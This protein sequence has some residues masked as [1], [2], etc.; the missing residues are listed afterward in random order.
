MNLIKPARTE[1]NGI[2]TIAVTAICLM[3]LLF[4]F[5]NLVTTAFPAGLDQMD[6]QVINSISAVLLLFIFLILASSEKLAERIRIPLGLDSVRT[7]IVI[8][9]TLF[10]LCFLL[11]QY[12]IDQFPFIGLYAEGRIGWALLVILVLLLIAEFFFAWSRFPFLVLMLGL[13]AYGLLVFL[14]IS[15][16][17]WIHSTES[18]YISIIEAIDRFYI[19]LDPYQV[20]DKSTGGPFTQLPG[21]WLLF[22]PAWLKEFDPRWINKITFLLSA[23][24]IY[25]GTVKSQKLFAAHLLSVFMLIPFNVFDN[26]TYLGILTFA[27]ALVYFFFAK[28]YYLLGA[29]AIGWSLTISL[30][31][32][33]IV[34]FALVY[35]FKKQPFFLWLLNIIIT[36]LF[37]SALLVSFWWLYPESFLYCTVEVWGDTVMRNGF[38]IAFLLELLV[39]RYGMIFL[40]VVS[41]LIFFLS[42]LRSQKTLSTFFIYSVFFAYLCVILNHVVNN[43]VFPATCLMIIASIS[44]DRLPIIKEPE[45]E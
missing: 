5:G 3:G 39:G 4:G 23:I 7:P 22:F 20:F 10:T 41:F 29:A 25:F 15:S 9:V 13:T 24:L 34:P 26:S 11:L 31:F 14:E 35:L 38:N 19:G 36:A 17:P 30:F 33:L 40:Q 28:R 8:S 32:W 21:F 42:F 16:I 27:T 45:G 12:R 6:Q 1:E 18:N 43:Y 37:A 44:A 2:I